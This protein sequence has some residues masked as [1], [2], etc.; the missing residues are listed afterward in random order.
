MQEGL[1][2]SKDFKSATG[3]LRELGSKK[4]HLQTKIDVTRAMLKSQLEEMRALI[5]EV[6][7]SQAEVT[8]ISAEYE[9]KVLAGTVEES[10]EPAQGVQAVQA[11]RSPVAQDVIHSLTEELRQ[12]REQISLLQLTQS[13]QQKGTTEQQLAQ[14]QQQPP[15]Q[16]PDAS[17]PPPP[18][19]ASP[20]GQKSPTEAAPGKAAKKAKASKSPEKRRSRSPKKQPT[21]EAEA[22]HQEK[23]E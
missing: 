7:A 18:A 21:G 20:K 6:E 13:Q 23:Q 22:A 10:P 17:M 16:D 15:P 1:E 8:R 2:A 11:E 14:A 12:A 5:T 4:L 19:D 9:A 3:R